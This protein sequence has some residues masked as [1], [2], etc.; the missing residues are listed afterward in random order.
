MST[1]APTATI[2]SK[3]GFRT[4]RS[5]LAATSNDWMQTTGTISRATQ[6]AA[7]TGF[8][9]CCTRAP[10]LPENEACPRWSSGT[11]TRLSRTAAAA[12]RLQIP[13]THLGALKSCRKRTLAR[14]IPGTAA[15]CRRPARATSHPRSAKMCWSGSRALLSRRGSATRAA[16]TAT[17]RGAAPAPT[18]PAGDS[19]AGASATVVASTVSI[20]V[21]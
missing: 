11:T 21:K 7:G 16:G 2:T 13:G 6:T 14:S 4:R 19:T 15:G 20:S 1:P 12:Q 5:A 17:M 9:L 3:C 10:P 18:R 8:R